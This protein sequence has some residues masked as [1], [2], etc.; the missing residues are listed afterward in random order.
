[1]LGAKV[2]HRPQ[3]TRTVSCPFVYANISLRLNAATLVS[4]QLLRDVIEEALR[5]LHGYIGGALQTDILAAQGSSATIKVDR[6]DWSKL[7]SAL[8]LLTAY[9]GVSC[10]VEVLSQSPFLFSLAGDSDRCL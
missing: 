9:K 10:R 3:R 2:R 1:M 5:Q 7:W 6:R 8:T 4:D